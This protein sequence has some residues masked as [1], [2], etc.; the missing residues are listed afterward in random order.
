MQKL[1]CKNV[2][3]K[4]DVYIHSAPANCR[5]YDS[6]WTEQNCDITYTNNRIKGLSKL[7]APS[8]FFKEIP[9]SLEG[10]TTV[11]D[12]CSGHGAYS[13]AALEMGAETVYMCDGSYNT[14]QRQTE[15]LKN[16]GDTYENFKDKLI[17]VQAD[18]EKIG[19]VFE[20]RSFDLVFQRY[21]LH[22]VRD[23]LKTMYQMLTLVK[24]GGILS[25]NC[26]TTGC[27]PQIV[28]DFRNH[29]LKKDFEYVRNF[30][31][32]IG[33]INKQSKEIDVGE[34]LIGRAHMSPVFDETVNYLRD[35]CKVY[36]VETISQ[37]LHYEDFNTPYLHN[38][39]PG[40]F[41]T[42]M[43]KN[44][45]IKFVDIKQYPDEISF[46]VQIPFDGVKQ[47]LHIPSPDTY[48]TE[49]VILGDTLIENYEKKLK[50]A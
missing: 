33:V 2:T 3:K 11:L 45:G 37:K 17:R 20:P 5:L 18:V 22:H 26:F 21:A 36:G 38:I 16:L 27:T 28:R 30:L 32:P 31:L 34:V 49:D 13:I 46:T 43:A 40:F 14:L 9:V 48:S 10:V 41:Y 29:F 8:S 6:I 25:F 1:I 44:L 23:P 39:N 12:V 7:I 47:P 24:P 35:L 42:F 50:N 15:K 4:E 19:D